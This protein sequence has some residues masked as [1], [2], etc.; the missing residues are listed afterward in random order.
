MMEFKEAVN[1]A[2]NRLGKRYFQ[3]LIINWHPHPFEGH[4]EVIKETDQVTISYGSL[5]LAFYGLTL[6][7]QHHRK[8]GFKI[9]V[10]KHF[11]TNGLMHDCSR[12][13]P[14]NIPQAKSFIVDLALMGLN[15]FMLYTED[16]YEIE[17]EPFFGYFRGA[18]TK[19]ELQNLVA[20]GEAFGVELVPCIQTLSHLF[21]A[22]KWR[23]F[24][25]VRDTWNTLMV[26]EPATYVLIEKMLKTCRENFKSK[27]IHIGMDE[28]HDLASGP[29]IF[30][31]KVLDK[32]E[33]FL[34][35][36]QKVCALC[37]RYDFSPLMWN[38]MFFKLNRSVL[39][40]W[41]K[42]RKN[43]APEIKKVIPVN[44]ALVYW[45]YYNTDQNVYDDM[46]QATLDTGRETIFAGGAIR[47]TGFAPNIIQSMKISSVGL[48][49]AIENG[50]QHVFVTAWGDGGNEC[51]VTATYPSLALYA[52]FDY[53][54]EAHR[55]EISALVKAVTGDPLEMW[56]TLQLPNHLRDE[57]LP[58]ENPSKFC[59][60]QDV[61]LGI[62]DSRVKLTFDEQF[63]EHAQTLK[64][65]AKKSLHYGYV[66]Q[67][68]A[69]FCD[70]LAVKA[71][72]GKRLREAYQTKDVTGLE[73]GLE[74]LRLAEKKLTKFLE[75]FR[76]Q[77]HRENK[78]FGFEIIDGRIG[79]LRN[80][81]LT[82][83]Q[84][85]NDYLQKKIDAI[86]EL[87]VTILPWQDYDDDEP[88]FINNWNEFASPNV[89]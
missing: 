38:D 29:F 22:L 9:E 60:Y 80:R 59:F 75:S 27:F 36:L 57:Q 35:H 42:T 83:Y 34:T 10:N 8:K 51:S 13:G 67:T 14:L 50:V 81:L 63:H 37:E 48:K 85:V 1:I 15:R 24:A 43:L 23:H 86:P 39:N 79:F 78:P 71:T 21:Q 84:T 82:A 20:F 62:L 55:E 17:G 76:F 3:N 73:D 25:Q 65:M 7:K 72:L 47:W 66:Y 30:Q 44:V 77:W 46:L 19:E 33:M 32:T 64:K 16:V 88:R 70:F 54:G 26:G 58:Y 68:L 28:A 89:Y 87:E 69:D 11:L 5:S 53:Q 41:T 40:D 45:D 2:Q 18:Y 74:R 4:L 49:S 56:E 52:L 12:N 31:N 61:L 6:I